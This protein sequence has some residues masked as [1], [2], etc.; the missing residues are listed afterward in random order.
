[1]VKNQQTSLKEFEEYDIE[2]V[3]KETARN[4]KNFLEIPMKILLESVV[5]LNAEDDNGQTYEFVIFTA[6]LFASTNDS[7]PFMEER[8]ITSGKVVIQKLKNAIRN[9]AEK[10]GDLKNTKVKVIPTA[11]EGYIDLKGWT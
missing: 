7:D 5:F 11:K 4:I 10:R 2:E 8:I 9:V 6:E 1:M 3:G